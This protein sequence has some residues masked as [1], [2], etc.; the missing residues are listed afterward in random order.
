VP[1][2]AQVEILKLSISG[3]KYIGISS[4]F[5]NGEG[6]ISGGESMVIFRVLPIISTLKYVV[7]ASVIK[8]GSICEGGNLLLVA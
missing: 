7:S 2:N 5:D 3:N 6:E 4:I 1:L 8:L